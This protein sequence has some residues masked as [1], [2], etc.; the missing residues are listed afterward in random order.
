MTGDKTDWAKVYRAAAEKGYDWSQLNGA[1]QQEARN[2]LEHAEEEWF[3]TEKRVAKWRVTD[4]AD[5][6][7]L[8]RLRS[9]PSV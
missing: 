6:L 5:G 9:I 2:L 8:E 7:R 1:E 3:A 4:D